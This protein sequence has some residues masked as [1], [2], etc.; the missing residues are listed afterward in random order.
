MNP[1]VLSEIQIVPVKPQDGLLAFSSF[2][3]NNSFFVGDVAIYSRLNEPGYRLV[4]PLRV[5]KNGAKIQ[6][7]HPINK[8]AARAIEE[9]TYNYYEKLM[10]RGA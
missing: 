7:F 1:I 9:P 4:Y 6:C 10:K 2:V 5:L 8:E 3:L